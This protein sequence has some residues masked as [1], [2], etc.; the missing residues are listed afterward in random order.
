MKK[1]YIF[2][3][4][5]F[6]ISLLFPLS[7]S[8]ATVITSPVDSRPIST[9]YLE[10]LVS[11]NND[12]LI[13]IDSSYLDM[14]TADTEKFADSK[15]VR[16]LIRENVSKNNSSDTTVIIN[17]SSYFT[18]GLVGSRCAAQYENTDTALKELLNL[19]TDYTQPKYY[20]NIAMPRNLPETRGQKI[21]PDEEKIKGLSYFYLQS[22]PNCEDR[23]KIESTY[24][25]VSPSQFLLEYG[26]VYNKQSEK[27]SYQ[28]TDWEKAFLDYCNKNYVNNKT[29]GQYIKN[30]ITPFS[31]TAKICDSLI[32]W[33]RAGKI[34]E[35]I[36]GND[37]LQLPQSISYFYSKKA[38]WVP[39]E[40]GTPVKYSFSRT[41]MNI[42]NSSVVKRMERAFSKTETDNALVGKGK[43]IN[44]IFGMDEIP[45]LIYARSLAERYGSSADIDITNYRTNSV[46]A[47]YDV[48]SNDK[49]AENARNFISANL[50]P[51]GDKT[52]MYIFDYTVCNENDKADF[53]SK[54]S[55]SAENNDVALIELYSHDVISSG[56]NFVFRQ[57]LSDSAENNNSFGI[58]DL[59]AFSAW[60][61]SANAIGL[62]FANAGVYS[63]AKQHCTDFKAVTEGETKMLAQHIY[64]DGLYFGGA[65][66]YL[67]SKGYKP[68]K[69]EMLSSSE[70]YNIL[71][72][73][74]VTKA[75][76]KKRFNINGKHAY[77]TEFKLE[78]TAFPWQRL[79]DC[80]INVSCKSAEIKM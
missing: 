10:N 13:T 32:R 67:S 16:E 55:S 18:G 31:E 19:V 50:A 62:G 43:S 52:D 3:P 7:V 28:L 47:D 56:S 9:S 59:T 4:F 39:L 24:S 57:L 12:K 80:K 77:L 21:W 36:I 34:D 30:Y 46:A 22:N 65:R 51:S 14:F 79:F 75:F 8:A 25:L 35:I 61:T 45:Q 72:N 66:D 58:A 74:S 38:D 1:E 44:F 20:I 53:I 26:Y 15:K 42:G 27:G 37:D 17:T 49:L 5:L 33:Q 6:F 71:N 76:E 73:D 60:N 40:N 63:L 29:Y 78:N 68:T 11:I 23:E 2:V 64:E 41:Y 70:L 48:L 54:L 69:E